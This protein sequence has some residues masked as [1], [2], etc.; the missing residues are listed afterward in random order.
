[1]IRSTGVSLSITVPVTLF[2]SARSVDS[3][4]G[5]SSLRPVGT[6]KNARQAL[7]LIERTLQAAV[8]NVAETR[9]FFPEL[10]EIA[11]VH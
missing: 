9:P 10:G 6:T 5:G 2:R 8:Q 11:R 7:F 1:M 3:G 4:L